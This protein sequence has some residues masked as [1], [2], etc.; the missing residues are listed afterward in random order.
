M[1]VA[2]AEI[3][4]GSVAGVPIVLVTPASPLETVTVTPAPTAASL[5]ALIRSRLAGVVG[6]G[7]VAE[8]LVEHVDVVDGDRVVDRL[9]ER[10]VEARV[11]GAEDV[12][13]DQAGA[14]GDALDA[15]LA[16]AGRAAC[17]A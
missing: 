1:V 16:G 2:P 4:F 5:A 9:E 8:R 7:V 17:G 10:G 3:T 11:L 15:D 12:E 14:R 13:P 6:I